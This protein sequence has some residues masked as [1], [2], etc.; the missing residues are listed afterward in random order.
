VLSETIPGNAHAF[1]A[2]HRVLARPILRGSESGDA[3]RGF[4]GFHESE[5][6]PGALPR[7]QNSP[8]PV[9]FGLVAEQVNATGFCVERSRNERSWLYRVRPSAQQRG[10]LE[11]PHPTCLGDFERR[12]PLANL[13]GFR[14]LPLPGEPTD[15][16]DGLATVA[17]AGSAAQRRG[18][19]LHVYSANRNMEERAFCSSDGS[20]LLVP[21]LGAL[22]L[23]TEL[24][25]LSLGPGEVA[26]LP[27]GLRFSV[28]LRQRQARG[29]LAEVFGG[30]FRLPERGPVGANGLTEARHFRAPHAW[31]EDRL[32]VG[33]ELMIKANG[34]IYRSTQDYSPFDVV[35]W[36]GNYA[37]YVYDLMHFSPVSNV[38]FDHVDPSVYTVLSAPLDEPGSNNLDFVVFV[39]RWDPS[40]GTFRPPYFHRNATTEFN[41][42]IRHPAPN[43][44]F[45][46]GCCFLT[47]SMLPHGVVS[48]SVPASTSQPPAHPSPP[49][50]DSLWFQ[51]ETSLP[52]SLTSWASTAPHRVGDWR[53]YWGGYRSRFRS[54]LQRP[55]TSQ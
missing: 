8:Q 1:H 4:A 28:L 41:G 37:P 2:M 36:H 49:A 44:M 48:S 20:M 43:S 13:V 34:R 30:G 38:R 26:V 50:L 9:P 27:R 10:L 35:A 25:V 22:T 33:Y 47:P 14:P 40:E 6:L 17:G 32:S 21:E 53:A 42:I 16:V 45:Q 5:D 55:Q 52:C 51:F 23:L 24:G 31:H 29:Y 15:F 7:V 12:A 18:F 19:A 46:A 54:A 11:Y 3:P 39:P